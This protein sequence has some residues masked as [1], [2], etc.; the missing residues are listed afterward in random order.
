MNTVKLSISLQLFSCC[1]ELGIAVIHFTTSPYCS[2]I[3]VIL[4]Y[5]FVINFPLVYEFGRG[6][7]IFENIAGVRIRTLV[8]EKKNSATRPLHPSVPSNSALRVAL[9]VST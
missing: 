7:R 1:Y 5:A 2:T 9:R 8:Y 4:S 6:V 3:F